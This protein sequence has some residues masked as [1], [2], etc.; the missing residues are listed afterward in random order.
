VNL[1]T[2]IEQARASANVLEHPFYRRWSAGELT[3]AELA[4]YAGEYRH[5][6]AALAQA[7][8]A[9]ARSAE[10]GIRAGLEAHAAEEASHL[11]LWDGFARALDADLAASPTP[12]TEECA[13]TWAGEGRDLLESLVALYAIESGQPEISEVKRAGLREHY[14]LDAPE[15]TAYFDLHAVLDREH[16]A[17]ARALIEARVRDADVDGLVATAEAVLRANWRLLDGVERRSGR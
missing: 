15:A 6:V 10:P 16:A 7:A 17:A 1:W 9:A 14:G 12:E 4:T 3:R 5:A 2:R 13:R 8:A 11:D